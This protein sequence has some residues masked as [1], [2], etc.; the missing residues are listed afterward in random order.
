MHFPVDPNKRDGIWDKLE[1]SLATEENC[2]VI[3]NGAFQADA[4][5]RKLSGTSAKEVVERLKKY[6]Y[7]R[8]GVSRNQPL[9]AHFS[10]VFKSNNSATVVEYIAMASE[11]GG[12]VTK[13]K[14]KKDACL[15]ADTVFYDSPNTQ[16]IH[17]PIRLGSEIIDIYEFKD[18]NEVT[19]I[20]RVS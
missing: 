20:R 12:S 13:E 5:S 1:T 2:F 16:T 18:N 6:D 10:V 3:G 17:I 14:I 9:P 19:T 8:V 4:V 15:I 11:P 7:V